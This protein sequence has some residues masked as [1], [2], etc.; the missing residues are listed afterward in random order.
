MSTSAKVLHPI[1][2]LADALDVEET[3]KLNNL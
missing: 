1:T 3:R 2:I